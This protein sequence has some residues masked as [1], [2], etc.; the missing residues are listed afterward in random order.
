[1]TGCQEIVQGV[2]KGF[3]SDSDAEDHRVSNVTHT[4]LVVDICLILF[5]AYCTIVN[6]LECHECSSGNR[7][8]T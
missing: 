2:G 6:C 7:G 8:P 1:M 5:F 4:D 3:Q